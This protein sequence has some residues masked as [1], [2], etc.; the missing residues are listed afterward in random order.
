MV[1]SHPTISSALPRVASDDSKTYRSRSADLSSR[2]AG[3]YVSGRTKS[4]QLR[5]LLAWN[6]KAPASGPDGLPHEFASPQAVSIQ[7]EGGHAAR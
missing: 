5:E 1:R 6:W 3:A 2:C 4:H 7:G